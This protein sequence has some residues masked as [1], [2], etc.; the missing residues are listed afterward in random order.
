MRKYDYIFNGGLRVVINNKKTFRDCQSY[1][2]E[3]RLGDIMIELYEASES[4]KKA[5]EAHE[6]AERRHQEEIRQNEERRERYNCEV[7]RTLALVNLAEDYDIA[8][9]IRSYIAVLEQAGNHD[10][11]T[12]EWIEWAKAKA[13]WYD[14]TIA[15]EDEFFGRRAHE[16]DADKKRLEHRSYWR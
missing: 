5:C 1:V 7:D 3:D 11:K 10:D 6:E 12:I 2:L 8:S 16:K 13:D 9:K 15:K 4:I 14:P